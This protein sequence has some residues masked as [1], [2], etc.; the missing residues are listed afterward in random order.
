MQG[1]PGFDADLRLTVRVA[2][3]GYADVQG[4]SFAYISPWSDPATW[5]GDAVPLE[6]DYVTI[7]AGQIVALDVSPPPL[8]LLGIQGSLVFQDS[9]VS[10]LLLSAKFSKRIVDRFHSFR[11]L[12]Q[13][14]SR[15]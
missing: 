7:P 12:Q 6:G 13:Q 2:V 14:V 11:Q 15:C 4:V 1:Y 10:P 3:F 5:G 8:G 9:Q